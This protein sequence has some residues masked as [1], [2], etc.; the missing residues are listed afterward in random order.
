MHNRRELR[1]VVDREVVDAPFL[2]CFRVS[3]RICATDEPEH[4][5]DMPFSS[6]GPEVLARWCWSR[7]PDPIGRE[8]ATERIDNSRGRV[9]IIHIERIAVEW[10]DLRRSSGTG[11]RGLGVDDPFNGGEH[12]LAHS[13]VEC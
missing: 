13:G 12:A 8:V 4:G 2:L 7:L 10:C 6:E 9:A 5:R 11:R 3:V 1:T